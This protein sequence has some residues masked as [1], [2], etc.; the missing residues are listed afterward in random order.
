M[1][2]YFTKHHTTSHH[3]EKQSKY[4]VPT[5][6]TR[7]YE[8]CMSPTDL[9]V[10]VEALPTRINA[11]KA[12]KV[13]LLHGKEKYNGRKEKNRPIRYTRYRRR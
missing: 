10:C 1:S 9:Q 11:R 12:D 4:F 5:V 7:K 6:D 2:D 8:C 13:S 3:R